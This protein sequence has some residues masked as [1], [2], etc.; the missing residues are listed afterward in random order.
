M[1]HLLAVLVVLAGL[2]AWTA[3]V[4]ARL[5]RLQ[6]AIVRPLVRAEQWRILCQLLLDSG[7]FLHLAA[8]DR[9]LQDMPPGFAGRVRGP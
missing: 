4:L 6:T 1:I 3:A 8:R 9:L 7:R 2:Q 5:V